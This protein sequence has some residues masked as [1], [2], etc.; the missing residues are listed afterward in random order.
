VP[1]DPPRDVAGTI[2]ERA[3]ERKISSVAGI[4]T[5]QTM[6]PD[7]TILDQP[8]Y[9]PTNRLL[10]GNP[11]QMKTNPPEPTED[12]T[13]QA[14]E[15]LERLLAEFPLVDDVAKSVALSTL[16]TP[17][18]R[19]AFSVAPMHIAD[20]PVAGSGKS[21]LFDTAAV[22]ARYVDTASLGDL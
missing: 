14:L 13:R 4:I 7:G 11:P 18:V 21:Y 15:L 5:P 17:V 3:G 16:I 19:G 22:I 1:V 9:D 12:E 8:S 10:L 2:F 6:R 20:A